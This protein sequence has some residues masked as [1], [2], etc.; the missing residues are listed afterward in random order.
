M[1]PSRPL[2]N[3]SRFMSSCPSPREILFAPSSSVFAHPKI[4]I[5][6]LNKFL[7]TF[8][9]RNF[10]FSS[11]RVGSTL[12]EQK[13][14]RLSFICELALCK[15]RECCERDVDIKINR[16]GIDT[17]S[18]AEALVGLS[19]FQWRRSDYIYWIHVDLYSLCG[20]RRTL[21]CLLCSFVVCLIS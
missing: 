15:R 18:I 7:I 12:R 17:H 8:L 11:H 21:W 13:G 20:F 3:P 10:F 6:R 2:L 5:S 16:N 1:T 4:S 19:S 9:R 14:E